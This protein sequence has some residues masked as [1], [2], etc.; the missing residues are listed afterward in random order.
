MSSQV[1]NNQSSI[2]NNVNTGFGEES[3]V[4]KLIGSTIKG[5]LYLNEHIEFLM[6]NEY[7]EEETEYILNLAEE[8]DNKRSII[9]ERTEMSVS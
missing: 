2:M 8:L 4:P 1:G 5:L 3:D 7:W 6:L 9:A